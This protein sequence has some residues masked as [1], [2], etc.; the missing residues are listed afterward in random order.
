M[1]ETFYTVPGCPVL[2]AQV[3]DL[4]ERPYDGVLAS[5]RQ[6]RP[7][8]ICITGDFFFGRPVKSGLKI[9]AAKVLPFFSVCASLAPCFVSFGNHEWMIQQEDI[10]LINKT[11]TRVLDNTFTAC[12]IAGAHLTLGGLSSSRVSACQLL[13]KVG[14]DVR[15]H[16]LY[17]HADRAVPIVD[18]LDAYCA[19]P[20]YHVLLCHHP[21][22]YPKY[23]RDL[24]IPLILSGHA[25]G[26][27]VRIFG[28]G[29]YSPGQ[30]VFPKLTSGVKDGR[31]VV[32]RGLANRQKVPRLFNPPEIVYVRG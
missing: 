19:A 18:W 10:A 27:Q 2:I 12:D 21:E 6:N 13:C 7:D 25:H 20:G 24:D 30:G 29:L 4:H 17:A 1:Q 22:Y 9:E 8:L 16:D 15:S 31:L 32:S 5:L 23:L 26:G 11:G 14:Y 28:Q 3:S